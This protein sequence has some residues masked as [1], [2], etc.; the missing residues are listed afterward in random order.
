MLNNIRFTQIMLVF[1]ENVMEFI[2]KVLKLVLLVKSQVRFGKIDGNFNSDVCFQF[3]CCWLHSQEFS[4]F[5][6]QSSPR[7][8]LAV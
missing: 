1:C 4:L 3:Y 6:S 5:D 7:F 2:E 8:Q